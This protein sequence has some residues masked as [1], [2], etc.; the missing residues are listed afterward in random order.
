MAHG[1]VTAAP[2]KNFTTLS[3]P[4]AGQGAGQG[5]FAGNVNL[6][7]EIAG[8]YVDA[9]NVAHGF[10]TYPPYR[11]FTSFDPEGSV[12]TFTAVASAL[13]L[14]GR[15]RE[16]TLTRAARFTATCALRTARSP[17]T[18]SRAQAQAPARAPSASSIGDLG[19][20]AGNYIDSSGVNHGFVRGRFGDI[21]TFNV[22]D[23][24]TGSG[25][26]TIPEGIDLCGG[27][28]RTIH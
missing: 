11:T 5:T 26:G 15:S 4:D 23:A 8:Y 16:L 20:I 1:F 6:G 27:D 18:T 24:G 25:Q 28:H 10:V 2:F 3:E 19:A 22:S 17:N 14:E 7:G 9:S 13:N 12:D 21:T